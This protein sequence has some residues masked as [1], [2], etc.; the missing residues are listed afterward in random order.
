[1]TRRTTVNDYRRDLERIRTV[2]AQGAAAAL[3][4]AVM[5]LRKY[6]PLS[7]GQALESLEQMAC[8]A[9]AVAENARERP[10][11]PAHGANGEKR[12]R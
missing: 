10:H 5:A 9:E 12:S 3:R 4:S 6:P 11:K 8:E 1:M 7:V 2:R